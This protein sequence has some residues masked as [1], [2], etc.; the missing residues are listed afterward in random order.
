MFMGFSLWALTQSEQREKKYQY[1]VFP[2][3]HSIY[4]TFQRYIFFL[5]FIH[6]FIKCY[7]F[8]GGGLFNWCYKDK[9]L[10]YRKI[11]IYLN[12]FVCDLYDWQ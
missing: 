1:P 11:F 7:L 12:I 9:F 8:G 6:I 3:E 2:P 4:W 5:L 10:H